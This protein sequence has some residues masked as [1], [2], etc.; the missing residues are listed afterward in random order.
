MRSFFDKVRIVIITTLFLNLITFCLTIRVGIYDDYPMCYMED[1]T[2]K[3]FYVDI[4][5]YIASK[6][7]WDCIR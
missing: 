6:E 4:L 3:G 7:N 2:P 1:D 5:K